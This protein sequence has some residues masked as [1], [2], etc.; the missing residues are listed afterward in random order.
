MIIG[1]PNKFFTTILSFNWKK[2]KAS[3]V[4]HYS[5]HTRRGES[6]ECANSKTGFF[7]QIQSNQ[8]DIGESLS[9]KAKDRLIFKLKS[10]ADDSSKIP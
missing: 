7:D 5:D 8:V 1:L 4:I 2:D 3:R 6:S 9:S 10:S